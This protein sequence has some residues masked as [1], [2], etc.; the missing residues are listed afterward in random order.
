MAWTPRQLLTRLTE[1]EIKKHLPISPYWFSEDALGSGLVH[2]LVTAFTSVIADWREAIRIDTR[3]AFILDAEGE[4]LD[5]HGRDLEIPRHEDEEDSDYQ[6]R[7]LNE[8]GRVRT[9]QPGMIAAIEEGTGLTV[10]ILNPWR[11]LLRWGH[12]TPETSGPDP[13][14]GYGG[15]HVY[16]SAYNQ[17]FVI[18]VVTIGFS[19]STQII[20]E[21]SAPAG[22]RLKYTVKQW[23]PV[24]A[25]SADDRFYD[26]TIS[27]SFPVL[28]E[29]GTDR[30]YDRTRATDF[31]PVG[32]WNRMMWD[33]A[34]PVS[35]FGSMTWEQALIGPID[36]QPQYSL[37]QS[38]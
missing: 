26:R 22:A 31:A 12:R 23:T 15:T 38:A 19:V 1:L 7:I 29:S 32:A 37:V 24:L 5:R 17:A 14:W 30:L 10:S 27:F 13:Q 8:I 35:N 3:D 28:E 36:L 2:K 18:D 6:E 9:T 25:W 20:A 34:I 33:C 4:G 11:D 16:G 21:F